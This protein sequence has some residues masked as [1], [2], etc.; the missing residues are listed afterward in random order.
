MGAANRRIASIVGADVAIITVWRRTTDTR[1]IRTCVVRRARVTIITRNRVICVHTHAGFTGVRRAIV[2]VVTLAGL[3]AFTTPWNHR[4][5]ALAQCTDIAASTG[6]GI[7]AG[8][9]IELIDATA[10]R[11]T[12]V[13]RAEVTVIAI[14]SGSKACTTAACIVGR[15]GVMIITRVRI[16]GVKASDCRTARVIGADV[17][18]VA[19]RWRATNANPA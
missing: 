11:V 17:A 4:A 9:L 16:V 10:S 15:A 7:V 2:A 5:N 12:R 13:I 3:S 6:M 19:I 18:V 14:D 1:T 8:I